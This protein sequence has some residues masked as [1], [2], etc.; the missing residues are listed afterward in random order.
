MPFSWENELLLTDSGTD[1]TAEFCE[2]SYGTASNL[3]CHRPLLLPPPPLQVRPP[4]PRYDTD[5]TGY[6]SSHSVHSISVSSESLDN[7]HGTRQSTSRVRSLSSAFNSESRAKIKEAILKGRD[8]LVTKVQDYQ[9]R[10]RSNMNNRQRDVLNNHTNEADPH[11]LT[12]NT[13]P[14][15]SN[16]TCLSSYKEILPSYEEVMQIERPPDTIN[17]N[18]NP[19]QDLVSVNVQHPQEYGS[20]NE[21]NEDRAPLLEQLPPESETE[22][23]PE[24]AADILNRASSLAA[25]GE[26]D[27]PLGT[28]AN[29]LS[30]IPSGAALSSHGS[31]II[32]VPP[33]SPLLLPKSPASSLTPAGLSTGDQHQWLQALPGRQQ[34][35][36]SDLSTGTNSS[37]NS[38]EILLQGREA[39]PEEILMSL[40]FGSTEDNSTLT[41]R[42]PSRFLMLNSDTRG[43][44]IDDLLGQHS[45]L[46]KLIENWN[47]QKYSSG[48]WNRTPRLS[49]YLHGIRF[50]SSM[51]AAVACKA[52][53][54]TVD[55]IPNSILTPDN[56]L[57]LAE[58]GYY[59]SFPSTQKDESSTTSLPKSQQSLTA[60]EKRQK[61]KASKSS[62]PW[63][64]IIEPETNTEQ[65]TAAS[66]PST[67]T[68]ATSVDSSISSDNADRGWNHSQRSVSDLRWSYL[69][70]KSRDS[71]SSTSS[72][73]QARQIQ[74]SKL[75]NNEEDDADYQLYHQF[76]QTSDI[77]DTAEDVFLPDKHPELDSH[78]CHRADFNSS[79]TQTSPEVSGWKSRLSTVNVYGGDCLCSSVTQSTP[80][81]C[82]TVTS[83]YLADGECSLR[84]P[85]ISRL[86]RDLYKDALPSNIDLE[87]PN[88]NH[89]PRDSSDLWID[90]EMSINPEDISSN[91]GQ[92]D[93]N[94]EKKISTR[95]EKSTV[96][97]RY[98]SA[99]S[100]SSGFAE[101]EQDLVVN[102]PFS[103]LDSLSVHKDSCDSF[104]TISPR[105]SQR[106]SIN[107]DTT[108]KEL[109]DQS[110]YAF[111]PD[112]TQVSV[113][114]KSTTTD[115]LTQADKEL[116]T[117]RTETDHKTIQTDD[118][119]WCQ[120]S[121]GPR[122]KP[123]MLGQLSKSNPIVIHSGILNYP[124]LTDD[125][126]AEI[127]NLTSFDSGFSPSKHEVSV[128]NLYVHNGKV[129]FCDNDSGQSSKWSVSGG[130]SASSVHMYDQVCQEATDS[131]DYAH[132]T[133]CGDFGELSHLK[134][135]MAVSGKPSSK[136]KLTTGQLSLDFHEHYLSR[137]SPAR[138]TT[139]EQIRE[140]KKLLKLTN[141]KV[142]FQCLMRN[143]IP[144]YSPRFQVDIWCERHIDE[145]LQEEN[146][147]MQYA[148]QRYKTDLQVMESA[149][150][151]EFNRTGG[152]LSDEDTLLMDELYEL[153]TDISLEVV[154]LERLLAD[155]QRI[156][157]RGECELSTLTTLDVIQT[158]VE[159]LKEQLYV[160]HINNDIVESSTP[161]HDPAPSLPICHHPGWKDISREVNELRHQMTGHD[162]LQAIHLKKA[163]QEIKDS[164]LSDIHQEVTQ[165]LSKLSAR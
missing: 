4:L 9:H 132:N 105:R 121:S 87:D 120:C 127:K 48:N 85:E 66:Q 38:I 3:P 25:S 11:D 81:K 14:P 138:L 46:Q 73:S 60:V 155:R 31:Q 148:V 158:M 90:Y 131:T 164:V 108:I 42:I 134:Q 106:L 40:G 149:F 95:Q 36:G 34:S 1:L 23:L 29:T 89:I 30:E 27:L 65:H 82:D 53:A 135:M 17:D 72:I 137:K 50:L 13:F 114:D 2:P 6:G 64:L 67:S 45:E 109:S 116:L 58:Q 94:I 163:V 145:H 37:V 74:V 98:E 118:C 8:Y 12:R 128:L 159:V 157:R 5:C 130:Q 77:Y 16:D 151:R 101:P 93:E 18:Q 10:I 133:R 146:Q 32:D 86:T 83:G 39:D 20:N 62:Q 19:D 63:S 147:L 104:D 152:L 79:S 96:I 21:S 75:M 112:F 100:D 122:Y 15:Q 88:A 162:T 117:D 80:S 57:A 49:P 43:V 61:F 111:D 99:Q 28:D 110:P 78:H 150:L 113:C 97:C 136:S 153:W 140:Y 24:E 76:S 33:V 35:F 115:H 125:P 165:T 70:S 68:I 124:P 52:S 129:L 56:Q 123:P 156:I 71:Y 69:N 7:Y 143:T 161:D 47:T 51:R 126:L 84:E 91:S 103:N 44:S 55:S 102:V 142:S 59:D 141:Q 92:E 26:D 41:S 154:H 54:D 119:V 160:L 107:S 144:L 139:K 22:T